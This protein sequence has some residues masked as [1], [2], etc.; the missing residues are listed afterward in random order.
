MKREQSDSRGSTWTVAVAAV[1]GGFLLGFLDF[2]WI[3]FVPF[4][5]GGLGNSS[6]VW[7]VAA[8]LF[9]YWQRRG[10]TAGIIGAVV[11]LVVAVGALL[12]AAPVA[13]LGFGLFRAAGFA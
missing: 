2:V 1:V 12:L 13:V 6:A 8:F 9:A 11:L 5:F 4:P 3:K 7:A 10:W